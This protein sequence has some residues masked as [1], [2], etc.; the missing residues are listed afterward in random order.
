M[1]PP[2]DGKVNGQLIENEQPEDWIKSSIQPLRQENPEKHDR[3]TT[4]ASEPPFLQARYSPG[5]VVV[6][7][8]TSRFFRSNPKNNES[9]EKQRP[10]YCR[11]MY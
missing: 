5:K 6:L 11:I 8:S 2:R 4:K 3:K 10:L 9:L 1:I 7:K